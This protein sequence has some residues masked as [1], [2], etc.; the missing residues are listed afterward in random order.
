MTFINRGWLLSEERNY[1]EA[2]DAF[3]TALDLRPD[4][5][6]A[7]A[8]LGSTLWLLERDDEAMSQLRE[9]VRLGPNEA[10]AHYL[11]GL[12]FGDQQ[13]YTESANEMEVAVRLRP[14]SA[15]HRL[16]L[17]VA[18]DRCD[19]DASVVIRELKVRDPGWVQ[20]AIKEATQL[21]EH[22]KAVRRDARHAA[23]LI[24]LACKYGGPVA[25]ETTDSLAAVYARAGCF[26]E[27]IMTAEIAVA[28]AEHARKP[29]LAKTIAA[30]LACYRQQ[31]ADQ[32][33]SM[34]AS[35]H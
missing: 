5:A 1:T 12:S 3:A 22:R 34:N 21:A 10:V 26:S 2:A 6:L 29:D 16:A 31:I 7:R 27:A 28:A 24:R 17:A 9:A 33:S 14:Q 19:Q 8:K 4:S 20:A 23:E 35:K 30:R 13:R 25:P 11:L 32:S 18:L 15:A